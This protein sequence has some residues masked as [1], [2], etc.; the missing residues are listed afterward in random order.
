MGNTMTWTRS[1]APTAIDASPRFGV[2]TYGAFGVVASPRLRSTAGENS[3]L[4][5]AAVDMTETTISGVVGDFPGAP[6]WRP[7]DW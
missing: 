2:P 5:H 1:C 4:R 3:A 7:P 6:A